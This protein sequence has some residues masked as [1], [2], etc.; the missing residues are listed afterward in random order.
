MNSCSYAHLYLDKG[1]QNIQWRKDS[2]FNKYCWENWLSVCR[3]L[4][5]DPCL[6]PCTRINSKQVKNLNIR[7]ETVNLV[8]ERTGN[9]LRLGGIGNNL[10]NRTQ[11]AQQLRERIDKWDCMKLQSSTQ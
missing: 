4:K 1:A 8:Q 5:L 3:K 10:L 9:T 7:S 11:L 2:L 6:S